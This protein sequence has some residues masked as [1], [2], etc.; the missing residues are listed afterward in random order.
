MNLFLIENSLTKD[1]P[2]TRLILEWQGAQQ[3]QQLLLS[4][5]Q[6]PEDE[7]KTNFQEAEDLRIKNTRLLIN[8]NR[9]FYTHI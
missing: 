7:S 9:R 2:Q 5:H 3:G 8:F 6:S 4:S 1:K